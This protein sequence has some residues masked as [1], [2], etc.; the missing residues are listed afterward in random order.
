[1]AVRAGRPR[2]AMEVQGTGAQWRDRLAERAYMADCRTLQN[3]MRCKCAD[4]S[5]TISLRGRMETTISQTVLG[6]CAASSYM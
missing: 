3:E 1:M 4:V 5:A 2:N 6:E